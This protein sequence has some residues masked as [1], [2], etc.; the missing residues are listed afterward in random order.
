MKD[1]ALIRIA[2]QTSQSLMGMDPHCSARRIVP[3][4]NAMLQAA[5]ANHKDEPF[6]N[7][8]TPLEV[9]TKNDQEDHVSIGEVVALFAQIRLV[10]ESL[11]AESGPPP[12]PQR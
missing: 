10:L 9:N 5:K 11:Q 12:E 2:E 1:E 7:C 8:L 3:S 6:L 4:Y